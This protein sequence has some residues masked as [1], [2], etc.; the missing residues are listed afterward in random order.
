M[1]RIVFLKSLLVVCVFALPALGQVAKQGTDV[2]SRDLSSAKVTL[3]VFVDYSC[4]ACANFNLILKEIGKIFP[5]DVKVIFRHLPL[6]IAGHEQSLLAAQAVEAAGIQGKFWEM[7][8]LV[9]AKQ[10]IWAI[11]HSAKPDFIRY[12]KTL[13]LDVE[14]F[15]TD[16]ENIVVLQRIY[17]DKERAMSLNINATPT[18]FLNGKQ[19][20]VNETMVAQE[21][22]KAIKEN[23]SK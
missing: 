21:L 6:K 22:E 3:E 1:Y 12:A 15:K 14:K 8:D 23:I 4:P 7:S 2:L 13:G 9:L 18:G 10:K 5:N 17:A 20:S 16:M 19:L 11:K